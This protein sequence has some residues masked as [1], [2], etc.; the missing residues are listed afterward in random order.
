MPQQTGPEGPNSKT[1]A[2]NKVDGAWRQSNSDHSTLKCVHNYNFAIAYQPSLWSTALFIRRQVCHGDVGKLLHLLLL[3]RPLHQTARF[4]FRLK[5]E[6]SSRKEKQKPFSVQFQ[7][8]ASQ[9]LPLAFSIAACFPIRNS[10]LENFHALPYNTSSPAG[11]VLQLNF[12]T[13]RKN[14]YNKISQA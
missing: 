5:R 8:L 13:M 9:N 14:A 6:K 11:Q 12:A 4:L 10:Y 1:N 7:F 2:S 3:V